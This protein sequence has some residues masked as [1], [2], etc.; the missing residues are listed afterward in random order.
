MKG[1]MLMICPNCGLENPEN[2][3]WCDCGYDFSKNEVNEEKSL[4]K[5]EKE[6]SEWLIPVGWGFVVLGGILGI[7]IG[8]SIFTNKNYDKKTRNKGL[9]IMIAG[10]LTSATYKALMK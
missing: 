10:V 9:I 1:K 8:I 2:A 3:Q 7:I 4:V 5:F 6:P